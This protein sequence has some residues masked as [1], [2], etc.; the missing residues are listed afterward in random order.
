MNPASMH[1]MQAASKLSAKCF[2]ASFLSKTALCNKPLVQAKILATEFV[3]VS[4][5]Y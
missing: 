4:F 2:K 3:D 1:S 5:F